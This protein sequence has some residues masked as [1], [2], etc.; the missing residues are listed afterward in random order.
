M[1]VMRRGFT[2]VELLVVIGIIALLI[3][4]LL[5]T[6]SQARKSARRVACLSNL[7]QG[8]TAFVLY[9]NDHDF[10]VPL[11]YTNG[12]KQFNY[13]ASKNRFVADEEKRP[14]WM[15]QLYVAGLMPQGEA[16][17]CPS[18]VDPLIQYDVPDNPW[19]PG[20][21]NNRAFRTRLGY[22]TRPLIDWPEATPLPPGTNSLTD[23]PPTPMPKL[24][25]HNNEAILADLLHEETQINERHEDGLNVAWGHGGAKFVDRRVLD[26]TVV[27]GMAWPDAPSTWEAA[28]ND[29]FLNDQVVPPVGVWA[30]L[31][32]E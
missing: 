28:W 30:N 21:D 20:T 2:L 31:D 22:G 13:A 12:L 6:L 10:R 17:Y 14:R 19:P 11:G 4:I 25:R 32:R 23:M 27:D 29:V 1:S 9:G 16:W 7:R 24:Q 3:S 5:P 26:E 18:E 15:G 8:H